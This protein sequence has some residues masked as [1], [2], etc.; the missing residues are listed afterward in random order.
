MNNKTILHLYERLEGLI[1]KLPSAL[2]KPILQEMTPIKNLFL[3][4]RPPRIVIAGEAGACKEHLLNALFGA[5]VAQA[6]ETPSTIPGWHELAFGSRGAVRLLDARDGG[7]EGANKSALIDEAPDL[8]LFL[9]CS[10]D[11]DGS[12]AEDIARL[13]T[14]L[15]FMASR[16]SERQAVAGVLI[17]SDADEKMEQARLQLDA[18]LHTKPAISARLAAT[19]AIT[20]SMRLRLDG[21]VDANSI[22]RKNIDRLAQVIAEELP[23]EARL[24]MAR[25]SGT[26]EV[27]EKIAQTLIKAC[28][29]MCAAIGVQPIPLADFPILTAIQVLMIGGIIHTS[30]RKM[31]VKLVA[32]FMAALGLNAGVGLVLREG[33]RALWKLLPVWGNIISGAIA[34]GGTYALGRAATA[35]FIEGASI[36]DARKLFRRKPRREALH[37]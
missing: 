25:L 30:G 19:L 26:R 32:E 10:P 23:E 22:G 5:E 20:A 4:Q 6:D 14:I 21:T 37:D 18:C 12:L 9:R 7:Q 2:Q 27:Q 31:G 13:N 33:S 11:I 8:F 24:E 34:G 16:G 35:Y 28:T 36:K 3:L 29:A 15:E 1:S 17:K